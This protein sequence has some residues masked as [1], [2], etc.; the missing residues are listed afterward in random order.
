MERAGECDFGV[1]K[2]P[3][4]LKNSSKSLN[5]N[6]V[7]KILKIRCMKNRFDSYIKYPYICILIINTKN[8]KERFG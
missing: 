4:S 7:K 1:I 8:E 5:D 6:K 2:L 3:L